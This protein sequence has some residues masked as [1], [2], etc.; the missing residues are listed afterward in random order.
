MLSIKSWWQRLYSRMRNTASSDLSANHNKAN[1]Q[2]YEPVPE[3]YPTFPPP[4]PQHILQQSNAYWITVTRRKYAAPRGVFEDSSLYAL[5]R[6]YEYIVLDKVFGY[7][8]M[9]EWFWR[10]HQ[11]R[12]FD[13][14]DPQDDEPARYAFLAC[15]TYLMVR[16]YN[17]RV[18][19][20]L[21]RGARAIMT[22]EETEEARNRPEQERRYEK[23]PPW[24]ENVPPLSEILS[25]P[26]HDGVTLNADDERADPDFLKKNILLWT[27]HIHFT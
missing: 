1:Q 24:A 14:P 9:L 26:T 2:P 25:V 17:A 22:I 21:E 15:I 19:I 8:N 27:P 20:G 11:W 10:Q 16:S 4:P 5:Y 18:S 13:I 7:R 6:L 23:V 12:V 3:D